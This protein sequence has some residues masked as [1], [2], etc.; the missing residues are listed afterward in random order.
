MKNMHFRIGLGEIGTLLYLIIRYK[1]KGIYKKW[2][3]VLI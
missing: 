2:F 3:G 1:Y